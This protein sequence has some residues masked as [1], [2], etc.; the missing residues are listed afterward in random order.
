LD[1]GQG[2]EKEEEEEEDDDDDAALAGVR[3]NT[4]P[5]G[6]ATLRRLV[7]ASKRACAFT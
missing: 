4:T 5:L 1:G 7:F 2:I 3:I 6:A